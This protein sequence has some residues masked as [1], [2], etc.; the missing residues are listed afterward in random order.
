MLIQQNELDD[1]LFKSIC[2][3]LV[4]HALVTLIIHIVTYFPDAFFSF[5]CQLAQLLV[6]GFL[7]L[8][9]FIFLI[10]FGTPPDETEAQTQ[11]GDTTA[12]R[13]PI[14]AWARAG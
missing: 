3:F 10:G 13:K 8:L 7:H 12:P 14:P 11:R 9:F 6:Y 5:G 4:I 2:R 1:T